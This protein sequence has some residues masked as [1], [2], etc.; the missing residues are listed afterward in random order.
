MKL[1]AVIFDV[2]GVIT[3]TAQIHFKC[4]K[5]VFDKFLIQY[6]KSKQKIF[7][8]F[9]ENDYLNYVDGVNRIDGIKKFLY[10]R[11]I[12]LPFGK[13]TILSL[14]NKK[15][16]LFL[17]SIRQNE[18]NAFP[19]SVKLIKDL[20]KNGIK[21][22]AI[23][24]SKNS[25]EVLTR[26]NV[27]KFF[28]VIVDGEVAR[29]NKLVGKPNPAI[30]LETA[31]RLK[32][33]PEAAIII[34]DALAGIQA[35][36]SGCFGLA[37]AIDRQQKKQAQFKMLGANYI[38]K[39]LSEF[40]CLKLKK[41]FALSS[42][43]FTNAT[44]LWNFSYESYKPQQEK[45]REALCTLSN[46]Y[47]ATRGAAEEAKADMMHYPGTYFAGCYNKL[48]SII[49][50]TII[51]N[52]DL[53]NM[54]NWLSLTF[55][56]YGSETWFTLSNCQILAYHQT[57]CLQQGVLKRQIRFKDDS[58]RIT[59]I[60]FSR[61]ISMANQHIAA[62]QF[63]LQ[64]E[65][66]SGKIILKTGL[67]GAVLNA[68][69]ERYSNLNN[70]HLEP[71]TIS[72]HTDGAIYLKM[73]TTQSNILITE[74]AKQQFYKNQQLIKV[75]P[76]TKKNKSTIYQYYEIEIKKQESI[77]L[78]KIVI[79][80]TSKDRAI[81]EPL[82][83]AKLLIKQ[84]KKY[85]ELLVDH[86]KKWKYLWKYCDIIFEGH[87]Y[88]QRIIRLYIFHL[89]QTI[90]KH[91]IDL[92]VGIPARGLHGEDYQGHIFW[93]E[94]FILPFYV[95]HF[96]DIARAI[97]LYRYRRLNLARYRAKQAGLKGALY[98]WQ[99][100]S[101]GEEV[102]SKFNFNPYS[103]N[104]DPDYSCYQYHINAAI[105]Y[106]IWQYYL[107]TDDINFITEYGAEIIF[108]IARFWA[109]AAVLNKK[110][111]RYEIINVVG[112]DEYHE[113]YPDSNK[114]GLKNNAYTN[115]MAVWSI[116]IALMI[117]KLMQ[118]LKQYGLIGQLQISKIEISNWQNITKR[119]FI[120]F[121]DKN[122]ISQFEDY[123]LLAELDWARYRKK[124]GNIRRLDLILKAEG[125]APDKYKVAKQAD[126]LMLFYL[127]SRDELKRIFKNLGYC[128]TN[129]ML[130][131]NI[132]YYAKR[133]LHGSTLSK[134]VFAY[135]YYDIDQTVSLG[136]YRQ[137]LNSDL[138][139]MTESVT[140]EGIH[141][142]AMRGCI[143]FV[144]QRFARL[145]IKR[146]RLSFY[147]KLPEKF[148]QIKFKIFF[149]GNWY[150]LI[151][152]HNRLEIK[153]DSGKKDSIKFYCNNKLYQLIPEQW[154]TIDL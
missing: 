60:T 130:R 7:M 40:D 94:L 97:L 139:Y 21:I 118:S 88:E 27:I 128:L 105:V 151:I 136:Y 18:V 73:R 113:K 146:K 6:S 39:D 95:F 115:V 71:V 19:G 108:E 112:P 76:K 61:F 123:E 82:H 57:L 68:G 38:V 29:K 20:K 31:K 59:Q 69:V 98:P 11:H 63:T 91:S 51:I 42:S 15:T 58:G 50:D 150:A 124:Y 64:A 110:T 33:K 83:D 103:R 24:A 3:D 65:N 56:I 12:N 148:K 35:A 36:K 90:T 102:T 9:T 86:V 127:F 22:A 2:D 85:E 141:L 84:N 66:W 74:L 16:R 153:V 47:I 26:A 75:L 37:I 55:K 126:V 62:L 152:K 23:S 1:K 89:L 81:S 70:K 154:L 48:M 41:V 134:L 147:P 77:S 101:N 52:E 54:P 142:G 111:N 140:H 80:M 129:N 32:V 122:I 4:W 14:A 28:D 34:E 8:P 104:W 116:E 5:E 121:H 133:T 145:Q 67:D 106:N 10:S 46:G 109:S 120:P 99:S 107:A 43:F 100:A 137:D 25:K 132:E 125:G 149:I 131:D 119:M 30:L 143:N 117:L 44:K 144:M 114:I 79:F 138:T 13:I 49:A 17:Q 135:V 93:D 45:F 53:V 87:A 92:D 78:E 72:L 96:P